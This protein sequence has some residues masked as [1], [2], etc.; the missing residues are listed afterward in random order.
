[1]LNY[2]YSN[3]FS[4][5]DYKYHRIEVSSEC[6]EKQYRNMSERGQDAITNPRNIHAHT[7]DIDKKQCHLRDLKN[8]ER[9]CIQRH[10]N[11]LNKSIYQAQKHHLI[12]CKLLTNYKR[13]LVYLNMNV[14]ILFKPSSKFYRHKQRL[15]DYLYI[16]VCID[17]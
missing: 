2:Y 4:P 10:Y 6:K 8:I 14:V 7:F 17:G 9:K 13:N 3:L 16:D 5:I 1:M 12:Y 11:S 15:E